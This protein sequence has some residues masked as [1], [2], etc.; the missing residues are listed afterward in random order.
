MSYATVPHYPLLQASL[1]LHHSSASGDFSVS[2]D[3][4]SLDRED[5]PK[6]V[7]DHLLLPLTSMASSEETAASDVLIHLLTGR[8]SATRLM[9]AGERLAGRPSTTL[10]RD[11]VPSPQ[12]EVTQ[13][14]PPLQSV[15]Q[16]R[17]TRSPTLSKSRSPEETRSMA[18]PSHTPSKSSMTPRTPSSSIKQAVPQTIVRPSTGDDDDEED[19]VI[20]NPTPTSSSHRYRQSNGQR[21]KDEQRRLDAQS[22]TP[23]S[24]QSAGG[25]QLS[26]GVSTERKGSGKRSQGDTSKGDDDEDDEEE[27]LSLGS[28]AAKGTKQASGQQRQASEAGSGQGD[29]TVRPADAEQPSRQPA[30]DSRERWSPLPPPPPASTFESMPPTP[31]QVDPTNQDI[32]KASAAPAAP[33]QPPPTSSL[34]HGEVVEGPAGGGTGGRGTSRYT[35]GLAKRK[36][37]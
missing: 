25:Q 36:R 14:S 37:I 20:F 2:F 33:L 17:R 6:V 23:G 32:P 21:E 8:Q 15:Q 16:Q 11:R 3:L 28:K 35:R 26:P 1:T 27:E 31:V 9:N 13:P 30:S 24:R 10:D 12:I 29:T 4:S 19:I 22:P 34:T 7:R 5:G 18:A